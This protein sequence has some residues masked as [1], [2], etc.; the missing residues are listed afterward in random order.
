MISVASY[1]SSVAF[2]TEP[3]LHSLSPGAARALAFRDICHPLVAN[4]VSNSLSTDRCVLITG[5]NASGKST[6]LKAVAI[7]AIF[8]QSISTCL[9]REYS[10]CFYAVFT[11]MALKDNVRDG[12]SY[13]VAELKSIKRILDYLN[14][15]VPSLCLIDEVLRGTNTIER[16]AA[17]SQVL[18]HLS[19]HNCICLAAT[20]DIELTYILNSH[21]LNLHFQETIA[22]NKIVFDYQLR[23]GRASSKNAIKLLSMMGYSDAIVKEAELRATHFLTHGVWKET[24]S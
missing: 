10:S 13:F 4:S 23:E 1:R 22:D 8:A 12:E 17:S 6:F 20:H 3:E 24:P 5:S 11:S 18:L 2:C 14:A 19:R 7:N 21:F 16:I 9:A 15:Q